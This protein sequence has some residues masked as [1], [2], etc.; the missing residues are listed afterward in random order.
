MKEYLNIFWA[1]LRVGMFTF[2]G[3]YVIIPVIEREIIKKKAWVTMDEVIEFYTV[4]QIM[5]GMIGVNLSIFIGNKQKGAFAGFLAAIGFV[6]PGT[7]LITFIAL[8]I[9]NFADIPIVQHAFAGIR[10]AVAALILDTVIKLVK[11][12]FNDVKTLVLYILIFALSALP[13]GLLPAFFSSPAFL[14][15]TSGIL[16]LIIFGQKKQKPNKNAA[17]TP[18]ADEPEQQG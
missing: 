4:S 7:T 6:L 16:G 18:N 1:F 3:G 11:G 15:V 8:F 9:S 12:V 13:S 14:V 10:I 5:P 17:L 2:G